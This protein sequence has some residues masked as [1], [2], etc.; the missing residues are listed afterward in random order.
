VTA[1]YVTARQAIL[2]VTI[3]RDGQPDLAIDFV[4]DTGF[5][6]DLTLPRAAAVALN[7]SYVRDIPAS[8]A[9]DESVSLSVFEATIVWDGEERSVGVIATG[10][11]PLLGTA[12]LDDL[13]LVVQFRENGLVTVGEI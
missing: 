8:L 2:P 13:E 7:L 6:G 12:L 4:V 5:T 1:G 11:R 3:R 10:K 9:N